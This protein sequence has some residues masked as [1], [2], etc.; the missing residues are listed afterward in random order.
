[1]NLLFRSL[2]ANLILAVWTSRRVSPRAKRVARK[3]SPGLDWRF[4]MTLHYRPATFRLKR[5]TFEQRYESHPQR[6]SSLFSQKLLK[7]SPREFID[8]GKSN[9]VAIVASS[10][11]GLM[12]YKVLHYRFPTVLVIGNEKRGL[13]ERLS[14][15]PISPCAFRCM[16]TATRSM[17]RSQRAYFCSR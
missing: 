12:D 9:G 10:P 2:R 6:E 7:C 11:A 4:G 14:K 15:R 16:G 3:R 8:W 13:S 1:M 5:K 17:R